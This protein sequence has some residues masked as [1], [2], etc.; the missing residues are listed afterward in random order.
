[1][2]KKERF[3]EELRKLEAKF[4]D[5]M[6]FIARCEGIEEVL[7]QVK[8][9]DRDLRRALLLYFVAILEMFWLQNKKDTMAYLIGGYLMGMGSHIS[10]V[11]DELEERVQ[12]GGKD[13]E[14]FGGLVKYAVAVL[15]EQ[16]KD[17]KNIILQ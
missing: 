16:G 14:I 7:K 12:R 17:L 2:F 6:R 9:V 15:S 11:I 1:M 8:N 10:Q 13:V 5:V 3:E 4:D